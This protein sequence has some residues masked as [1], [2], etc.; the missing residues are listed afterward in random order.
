VTRRSAQVALPFGRCARNDDLQILE[1][2]KRAS[3]DP[4]R[5][6][7]LFELSLQADEQLAQ[8]VVYPGNPRGSGRRGFAGAFTA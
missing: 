5:P 6:R 3:T 2:K 8:C 7:M 1:L 4:Q